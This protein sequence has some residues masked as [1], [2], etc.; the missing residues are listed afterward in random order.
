MTNLGIGVSCWIS[1]APTPADFCQQGCDGSAGS[2]GPQPEF[3]ETF[4]TGGLIV[5]VV[6]DVVLSAG[7]TKQVGE[8]IKPSAGLPGP[9][10]GA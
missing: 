6:D 2:E 10:R 3:G 4:L 7:H 1:N 5:D 9:G 8:L